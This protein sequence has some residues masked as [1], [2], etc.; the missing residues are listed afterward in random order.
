MFF[1]CLRGPVSAASATAFT[2]QIVDILQLFSG[3]PDDRALHTVSFP[4]DCSTQASDRTVSARQVVADV[5]RVM[6]AFI[7]LQRS[8][9]REAFDAVRAK[10]GWPCPARCTDL[11]VWASVC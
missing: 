6:A 3:M 11:L 10:P 1:F 9:Q 8:I 2:R 4:Q 7:A 5:T